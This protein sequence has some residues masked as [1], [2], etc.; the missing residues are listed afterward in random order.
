MIENCKTLEELWK[1]VHQI[2]NEHF[3]ENDLM[4]ILG[5]GKDFQPKFM[6]IF[7]NPTSKNISSDRGWKGPRFPFV[8][9]KQIWKV[10]HK[11]GMFDDWLIDKI[12]NLET[13]SLEFTDEILTFLK[14]SSF[15]FTNIV[16]WTG[17]N[18]TLP[19]SG[20][21]KLFLPILEKEIGIV[22]PKY[23]VAFGLIPF[24]NLTRQKIKL[25]DYYS[26]IIKNK[27]LNFHEIEFENFK[28]KIIPCHFPVGRGKPKKA[29]EI[30]KLVNSL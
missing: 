3:P 21:I 30:L 8:G 15:Y 22:Q 5:N 10:F 24:E 23:I 1:Q 2:N 6:F 13:W 12:D 28:T 11:A 27:K 16:K 19:D 29:V 18:A 7:I 9:T 25:G 14:E 20:K 17:K 26:E 4:P